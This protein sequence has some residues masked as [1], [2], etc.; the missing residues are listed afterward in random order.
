M[1]SEDCGY[2]TSSLLVSLPLGDSIWVPDK[3][4]VSFCPRGGHKGALQEMGDETKGRKKSS[5]YDILK[6]IIIGMHSV[7]KTS[8]SGCQVA[9]RA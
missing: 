9:G 1:L 7:E 6:E 3:L 4:V 2:V 8:G 5:L